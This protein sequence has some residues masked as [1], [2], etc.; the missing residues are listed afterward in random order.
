MNPIALNAF[1]QG[2]W[3]FNGHIFLPNVKMSCNPLWAARH[4]GMGVI[5]P[6]LNSVPDPC[7][8]LLA[9]SSCWHAYF[10]AGMQ[11]VI[12]PTVEINAELRNAIRIDKPAVYPRNDSTRLKQNALAETDPKIRLAPLESSR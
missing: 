3:S 5:E 1:R 9:P 2:Q 6:R 12:S 7:C 11:A 8:G 4:A 10:F